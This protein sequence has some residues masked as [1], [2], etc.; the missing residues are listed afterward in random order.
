M[1]MKKIKSDIYV[2]LIIFSSPQSQYLEELNFKQV[3]KRTTLQ[4]QQYQ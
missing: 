4:G 1:K 3:P 2:G